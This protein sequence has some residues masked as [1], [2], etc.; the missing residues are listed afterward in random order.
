MKEFDDLSPFIPYNGGYFISRGIGGHPDRVMD[1]HELIFVTSGT[2]KMYEESQQ[3]EVPAGGALLLHPGR[4]HGGLEQYS[5]DL[6]FYW[7]HF[8]IADSRGEQILAALPQCTRSVSP[9]RITVWF[10]QLLSNQDT[11]DTSPVCSG[12]ILTLILSQIAATTNKSNLPP[13]QVAV[14]AH[15]YIKLNFAGQVSTSD[16]AAH[17]Q[18]N[19]D[20][21]GR[22]FKQAYGMS[23]T[24]HLNAC[25]IAHARKLL[26]ESMLNINQTAEE[27]GFN[28]MAYFRRKFKKST[29]ITPAAY[30]KQY[31]K[32]HINT[33]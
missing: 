12:L 18:C 19:A 5:S 8:N 29:G 16:A 31:G 11:T 32:I 20:Y 1:S 23:L 15:D 17:L 13:L 6:K 21:L 30:R 26:L 10:R 28:D 22:V 25:R 14:K 33:E 7:F 3:F 9:E 24:D 2:L 4:K 27:S